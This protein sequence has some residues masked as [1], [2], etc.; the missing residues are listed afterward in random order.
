[1]FTEEAKERGKIV[2]QG[3]L[4]IAKGLGMTVVSE[5]VETREYV[6]FLKVHGGDLVQGYYFS[7]PLPAAEFEAL[8]SH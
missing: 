3:I 7:R 6:D 4:Q 5:G 1:M 8:L 2:V